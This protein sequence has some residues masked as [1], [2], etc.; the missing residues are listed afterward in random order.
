[1]VKVRRQR[2]KWRS[3]IVLA[4]DFERADYFLAVAMAAGERLAQGLEA[5]SSA[6][7]RCVVA[8]CAACSLC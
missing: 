7:E 5:G 2:A 6:I 3:K 4:G 8:M 1:M